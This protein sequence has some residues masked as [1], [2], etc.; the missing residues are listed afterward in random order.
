MTS[1]PRATSRRSMFGTLIAAVIVVASF[2]LPASMAAASPAG[3][4]SIAGTNGTASSGGNGGCFFVSC[5]PGEVGGAGGGASSVQTCSATDLSCVGDYYSANEPRLVVAGGG[6]GGGSFDGCSGGSG[7]G[8]TAPSDNGSCEGGGGGGN[9]T[10][11]GGLGL[12]CPDGD[13]GGTGATPA[14]VGTGGAGESGQE[15]GTDGVGPVGGDGY[16]TQAANGGGGGGGGGFYGGGGGG[17]TNDCGAFGNGGGAGSSFS[18]AAMTVTNDASASPGITLSYGS[19]PTVQSFTP[20]AEQT[21]VVP[22]GVTSIDVTATGGTGGNNGENDS[23]GGSGAVVATTIPVTS[24]ETLYLNV[25][26]NGTNLLQLPAPVISNVSGTAIVG[27]TATLTATLRDNGARL[28]GETVSFTLDGTAVGTAV[29]NANGIAT[30]SGVPTSDTLGVDTGGVTASFAG[31][32]TYAPA[33]GSGDLVVSQVAQTVTF[34]STAPSGPAFADTYTPTATGG[35]STNPVVFSIDP[36]TTNSACSISSGTVTFDH[37]GTC[38]ID[39]DQ[40]GDAVYSDAPTAQQQVVVGQGAQTVTFNSTAPSSPALGDTYSPTASGGGSTNPVVFSIDAATTSSACSISSGTVTFDHAGTC[41]IDADQTGNADYTAALTAQQQVAVGQA[42]QAVNFTSTAPT[43]PAPG[44]TYTPTAT[45]GGSTNPI[46]FSI[47]PSTTNSACSISS[48]TVTFNNVGTCVIDADQTGDADY[49][50]APTAQQQMAVGDVATVTALTIGPSSLSV[51]VTAPSLPSTTVTGMVDF[52]VNGHAI[53]S[54]ALSGGTASLTHTLAPGKSY[55]VV[56]TY[57]GNSAF[58]SSFSSKQ[59]TDPTIHA[60]VHSAKSKTSFGWYSGPVT[61]RFTCTAGS[62]TL[63]SP[64]PGPVTLSG[65]G[66][67]QHVSRTVSDLDGGAATASV[68]GINIDRTAPSLTVRG[69]KNGAV[70]RGAPR[71]GHCVARDP[72]SGVVRCSLHTTLG[73]NGLTH[74][75]ATAVNRAGLTTT[76]R[77][78][79]RTLT[80]WIPKVAYTQATGFALKVGTYNLYVA[81]RTQPFYEWAAPVN[82]RHPAGGNADFTRAGAGVWRMTIH[83][84]SSMTKRYKLWNLGVKVHGHLQLVRITLR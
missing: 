17:A 47:D 51:T 7:G 15:N 37:A 36:S 34:T 48:G 46:V 74:Y 21:F 8:G 63:S 64:C 33:S 41:V 53:G 61:I 40:A 58:I 3:G 70:Y 56:G 59:R 82:S 27:G 31:D 84:T 67:G 50:A 69:I 76:A 54:V 14:A 30:L 62:A 20:G 44:D 39:A 81:S 19:S 6:G 49:A 28:T 35:G 65:N 16:T 23:F 5:D 18:V 13:T 29:T 73:R 42:A 1:L 9:G 26:T 12:N 77:G 2:W 4:G 75:V 71:H 11:G 32:A 78:S 57:E 55:T 79:Y 45:G 43:A 22:A 68:T 66:A 60:T 38:V 10:G 83:I 72:Q 24:G 52:T 25:A 80:I